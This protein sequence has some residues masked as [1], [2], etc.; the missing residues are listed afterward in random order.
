MVKY[1]R[2]FL[3]ILQKNKGMPTRICIYV[4]IYTDAH[5]RP[6]LAEQAL[7]QLSKSKG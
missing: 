7:V 3:I 6:Y 2:L 4:Y 5:N 1:G